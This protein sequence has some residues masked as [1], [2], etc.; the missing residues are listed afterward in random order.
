[1]HDLLILCLVVPLLLAMRITLNG[2]DFLVWLT[3][4]GVPRVVP[5]AFVEVVVATSLLVVVALGEVVIL[6]ILLV[7]PS[8]HHVMQLHGSSR[9]IVP[10]VVERVLREEPILEATDDVFIDDVGDGGTR[11]EETPCVG[12][13]GLVHFLL[14]LGQV[15]VSAR[16]DHG[17]LEVINEGP[18]EVLPRVDG[19]WLEAFKPCEGHELQSHWE[20]ESFDIVGSP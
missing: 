10:E 19:V 6:L 7:S 11:L 15:M 8:C 13:Q 12:P 16:P 5:L 3:L 1:V 14:H 2:R 9:A 20:V 17:F 4:S 18:L